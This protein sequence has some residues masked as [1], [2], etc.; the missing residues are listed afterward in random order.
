MEKRLDRPK[1]SES[2]EKKKSLVPVGN[3]TP[4]PRPLSPQP[5][6]TPILK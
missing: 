2:V 5:V 3:Q 1:R 4:I 6:V